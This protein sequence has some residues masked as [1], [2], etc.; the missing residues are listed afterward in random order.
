MAN[1]LATAS[2]SE[3]V[4]WATMSSPSGPARRAACSSANRAL[5]ELSTATT[6][7]RGVGVTA[8]SPSAVVEPTPGATL[9][10]SARL[11]R[12]RARRPGCDRPRQAR[13]RLDEAAADRVTRELDPVAHP[14]LLEDVR[15]VALDGLLADGQHA[16]YL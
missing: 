12:R 11:G 16:R 7:R 4:T 2:G 10:S 3:L 13:S 6:M 14:E 9:L 8:V 15:A 1:A 5:S